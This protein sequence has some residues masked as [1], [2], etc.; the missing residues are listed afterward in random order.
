MLKTIKEKA[1]SL[2]KAEIFR[3]VLN[4]V[5][6]TLVHF[7]IL[8]FNIHILHFK[9]VGL[10]NFFAAIFGITTSFLGNRFFVFRGH[11][12][13]VATQSVKF[14]VLYAVLAVLHGFVLFVWTDIYHLDFRIGFVIAT[15]LQVIF[16][17]I[18]NKLLVFK[19]A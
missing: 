14:V 9:L 17:Y 11:S 2:D 6:A 19:N 7:A 5:I 12:D 16:S 3:F 8:N 15:G 10:A 18:G 4:G 13:G 1:T